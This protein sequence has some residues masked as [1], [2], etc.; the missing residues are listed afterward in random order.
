GS[1]VTNILVS[2]S[3]LDEWY[4]YRHDNLRTGAQPY[5]SALSDPTKVS[6]LHCV[7]SW[8]PDGQCG[9]GIKQ[10]AA[11]AF[12]ASPI[13][14]ND[15]VFIGNNNGFFYALDA[16][17]GK[18]KWQYPNSADPA[19]LGGDAQWRQSINSPAAYWDR[20]SNGAVI[21]AAQD[22]SLGPFC[23]GGDPK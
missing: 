13:L 17:T 10:P 8:P 1:N 23:P 21:F 9:P 19:L 20:P 15:T 6:T 11:A 5:A 12:S 4:T 16:A 14:V 2:C 22:P 7:W 18:L 3:P